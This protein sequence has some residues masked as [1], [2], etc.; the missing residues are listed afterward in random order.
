MSDK[1][2]FKKAQVSKSHD[3]LTSLGLTK[4]SSV[5]NHHSKRLAT[6]SRRVGHPDDSK[7]FV[8]KLPPNPH[9]YEQHT[10][11]NLGVNDPNSIHDMRKKVAKSREYLYIS[12]Q[13]RL[14]NP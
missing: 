5:A 3:L 9:Y 12:W 13:C 7:I 8:V 10:T 14:T 6:Q 1:K 11:F 4:V 2:H